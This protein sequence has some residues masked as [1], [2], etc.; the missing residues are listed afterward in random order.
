MNKSASLISSLLD[1]VKKPNYNILPTNKPFFKKL[2]DIIKYWSLG[3]VLAFFIAILSS[4]FLNNIGADDSQ[5]ILQDF[6]KN[7]SILAI[8]LIVFFVGPIIEELTF[9][10]GLRYSPFNF[11]YAFV[12]VLFLLSEFLIASSENFEQIIDKTI[13]FFGIFYF[14]IV[15][16]L[17]LVSLGF[18]LGF[19]LSKITISKKISKFYQNNFPLIFYSSTILFAS[20][21]FFNFANFK[22]LYLVLPFLVAPQLLLGFILAYI[23][24]RYGLRWSIFYHFFHNSLSALPILIFSQISSDGFDKIVST[25]KMETVDVVASDK[26]FLVLGSVVS[27][28]IFINVVVFFILL[29]KD[30]KHYLRIKRS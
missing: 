28:F 3:I 6:F 19:I 23:R 17:V 4:A 18:L 29:L 11:A 1:Y 26:F 21:H 8:I 14:F 30:H 9:R 22:E 25:T 12:F 15:L 16:L 7:N 13:D 5:N 20:V 2:G 24:M 10:L 27:L